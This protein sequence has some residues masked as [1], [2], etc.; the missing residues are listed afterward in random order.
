M[1]DWTEDGSVGVDWCFLSVSFLDLPVSDREVNRGKVRRAELRL[2]DAAA[3]G[4]GSAG[5]GDS[6]ETSMGWLAPPVCMRQPVKK[7]RIYAMTAGGRDGL[8]R[9]TTLLQSR[10]A[11]DCLDEGIEASKASC[12][13][14]GRESE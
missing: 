12:H 11:Y 4:N 2:T 7:L 1:R 6:Y 10:G 5:R 9:R 13:E 3:V 14:A 8:V